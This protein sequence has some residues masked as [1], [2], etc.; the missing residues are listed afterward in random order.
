[1][2]SANLITLN[3]PSVVS[4][5]IGVLEIA[6]SLA[7]TRKVS[8]HGI[9]KAGSSKQGKARRASTFSNWLNR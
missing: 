7:S 1:M 9:L 2:V 3:R 5:A 8:C 4:D 6:T